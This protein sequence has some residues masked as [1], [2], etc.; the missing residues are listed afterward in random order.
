M[1]ARKKKYPP[2][3]YRYQAKHPNITACVPLE[4]KEKIVAMLDGKKISEWFRGLII[5]IFDE[6]VQQ[7]IV[8][9]IVI[10]QALKGEREQ[11]EKARKLL[12]NTEDEIFDEGFEAG[13]EV[14]RSNEKEEA[15]K[16][17]ERDLKEAKK[18]VEKNCVREAVKWML[19]CDKPLM[20]ELPAFLEEHGDN[21]V[22]DLLRADKDFGIQELKDFSE[23]HKNLPE[24]L[25]S[26]ASLVPTGGYFRL[27]EIFK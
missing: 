4:L 8:T 25:N 3:Y 15:K 26:F 19:S 2:A 21:T 22:G 27:N 6:K 7:Q 1:T 11:L 13:A 24:C 5:S 12:K 23:R 17:F 14:G 10:K 18:K 16:R 9:E 20:K